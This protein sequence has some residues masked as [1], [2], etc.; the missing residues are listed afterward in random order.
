MGTNIIIEIQANLKM[1]KTVHFG[2][3]GKHIFS[4]LNLNR[5]SDMSAAD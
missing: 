3:L 4:I 1:R 2:L 5:M